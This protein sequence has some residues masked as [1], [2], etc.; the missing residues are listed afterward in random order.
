MDGEIA[1]IGATQDSILPNY[2]KCVVISVFV[3]NLDIFDN[4]VLTII[5]N[6][7]YILIKYS[8][9]PVY[10]S[11][12]LSVYVSVSM[13]VDDAIC[14]Y[15]IMCM[16]ASIIMSI[17]PLYCCLCTRLSLINMSFCLFACLCECKTL[18]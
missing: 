13:Y 10:L 5:I 17:T 11:V 18:F 7:F 6:R 2:L 16:C 1:V 14:V 8:R 3:I 9:W 15:V 4:S 12:D